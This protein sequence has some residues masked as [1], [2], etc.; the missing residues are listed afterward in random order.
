MKKLKGILI[1][2]TCQEGYQGKAERADVEMVNISRMSDYDMHIHYQACVGFGSRSGHFARL[3]KV[4]C[5]TR[6]SN[7]WKMEVQ[8]NNGITEVSY[9]LHE[10]D[11]LH[12]LHGPI[13]GY[14]SSIAAFT[15]YI[16]QSLRNL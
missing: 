13:E 6:E 11:T 14:L 16:N 5:E 9:W 2:A 8:M 7:I 1:L 10:E 3:V 4:T 12:H 15:T